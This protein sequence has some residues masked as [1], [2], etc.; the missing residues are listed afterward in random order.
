[1]KKTRQ[2]IAVNLDEL[3]QII[4]DG[5]HAPLSESNGQKLKGAFHALAELLASARNNEKTGAVLPNTAGAKP[6]EGN[7]KNKNSPLK[8]HGRN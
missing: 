8:G 7:D 6:E 3:D 2:R 5:T 4:D 1:M